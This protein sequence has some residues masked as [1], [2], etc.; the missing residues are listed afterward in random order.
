MTLRV[1]GYATGIADGMRAGRQHRPSRQ[2]PK[3]ER[4]GH[5][6]SPSVLRLMSASGGLQADQLAIPDAQPV[7][8]AVLLPQPVRAEELVVTVSVDVAEVHRLL[9][10]WH[11]LHRV[12]A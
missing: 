2:Q 1:R 12:G 5:R 3:E 4:A 11:V 9:R 10:H 6:A 8:A 7:R